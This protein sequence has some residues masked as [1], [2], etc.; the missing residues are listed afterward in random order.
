VSW[1]SAQE[2]DGRLG[3]AVARLNEALDLREQG[4]DEADVVRRLA[5][6]LAEVLAEWSG[7]Q[8]PEEPDA[9]EALPA[10]LSDLLDAEARARVFGDDAAPGDLGP[11]RVA[12]LPIPLQLS[13]L[14]LL[15]DR[16][17]ERLVIYG[18][19]APGRENHHIIADIRGSYRACTVH[20]RIDRVDGLPYFTW[21][22]AAKRLEAQL[23][24]SAELPLKWDYLDR[25]EGAGYKRRL[26]PATSDR[27]LCVASIYLSTAGDWWSS[28]EG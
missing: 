26:I 16:P 19:L 28:R 10:M 3:E 17:E 5:R 9:A 18:T 25:F 4:A 8:T 11:G 7:L 13:L 6:A 20:G 2:R 12:R 22:P 23:F 14:D 15:L 1:L 27:G 24:S 21:A